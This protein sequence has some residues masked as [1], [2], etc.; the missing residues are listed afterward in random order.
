[1]VN[2]KGPE[3]KS[4]LALLLDGKADKLAFELDV[5]PFRSPLLG[6]RS[7]SHLERNRGRRALS[8]MN[9]AFNRKKGEWTRPSQ[10]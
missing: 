2:V 8:T 10:V 1:M 6:G 3:R 5:F 9:R 7:E 4:G